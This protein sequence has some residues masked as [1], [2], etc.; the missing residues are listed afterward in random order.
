MRSPCFP[1]TC[2]VLAAATVLVAFPSCA[3]QDRQAQSAS[4][5]TVA[6]VA[7]SIPQKT[8]SIAGFNTLHF[9]W[10]DN[11]TK[12]MD[13]FCKT[14]ANYDVVGLLEV[15]KPEL[16]EDVETKLKTLTKAEWNHTVSSRKLGR[17]TYKEY[18]AIL[19]R[20]G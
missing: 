17:S 19:Y 1:H 14:L 13:A 3:K 2:L 18:Y 12:D 10:K 9:G 4:K 11:E 6:A 7:A 15:M 16:L 20:G 5:D 8:V